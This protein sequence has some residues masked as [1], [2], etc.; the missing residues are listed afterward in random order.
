L[1][2]DDARLVA[3]AVTR[4]PMEGIVIATGPS[5]YLLLVDAL[6]VVLVI[7]DDTVHVDCVRRA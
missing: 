6:A 1:S 7:D 4:F 5:E 2:L 3:R